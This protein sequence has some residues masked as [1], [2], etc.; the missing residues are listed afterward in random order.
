LQQRHA[1]SASFEIMN[2]SR[3]VKG[4]AHVSRAGFGV[5]PKRSFFWDGSFKK[6]NL[7]KSEEVRGTEDTRSGSRRSGSRPNGGDRLGASATRT[8]ILII[9]K[10]ISS[11]IPSPHAGRGA[12]AKQSTVSLLLG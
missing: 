8:I 3:S 2:A 9:M 6:A 12:R 1:R 5:R 7:T 4:S 10:T 11:L